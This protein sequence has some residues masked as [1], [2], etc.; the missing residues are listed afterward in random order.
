MVKDYYSHFA[1]SNFTEDI[2]EEV[3]ELLRERELEKNKWYNADGTEK[4]YTIWKYASKTKQ[5]DS[6]EGMVRSSIDQILSTIY[7]SNK[8]ETSIVNKGKGEFDIIIEFLET[9]RIIKIEVKTATEDVNAC[10]QFN[11][12]KKVNY[13]YAFL[14]GVAPEKCFFEMQTH[15]NINKTLTTKMSKG[16]DG[17][18]KKTISQKDLIP[19]TDLN[20]YTKL[21]ELG[22]VTL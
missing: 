15:E 4:K 18:Y 20:L 6:G 8:V 9:G 2:M 11:G 12:L 17:S 16:V 7:G 19:F 22:I 10:H 3:T 5:G 13:D 1:N 14:F 21:K